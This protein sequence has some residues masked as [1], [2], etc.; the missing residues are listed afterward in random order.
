M[1][2]LKINISFYLCSRRTK[3][4]IRSTLNLTAHVMTIALSHTVINCVSNR[5]ACVWK[6]FDMETCENDRFACEIQRLACRFLTI[7]LLRHAQFFWTH[8]RMWFPHARVLFPHAE[9]NFH[10]L[11]CDLHTHECDLHTLECD[12]HRHECDLDKNFNFEKLNQIKA[13][14]CNLTKIIANN[15]GAIEGKSRS[16]RYWVSKSNA[17]FWKLKKKLKKLKKNKLEQKKI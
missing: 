13:L 10:T 2:F 16:T 6:K 5:H 1:L 9:W 14:N 4:V 11:E 7:F 12:F 8:T 3:Y 17:I 15:R